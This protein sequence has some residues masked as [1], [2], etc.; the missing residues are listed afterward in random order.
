MK[1]QKGHKFAKGGKRPGAGRPSKAQLAE[2][3]SLRQAIERERE[4]RAGV[5]A[6]RYVEMAQEDPATMRHLVDKVLPDEPTE[7]AQQPPQITFINFADMRPSQ[8][9]PKDISITVSRNAGGD[10]KSKEYAAPLIPYRDAKENA[11][12]GQLEKP[13]PQQVKFLAFAFPSSGNGKRP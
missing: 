5:L 1:F 13:T 6:A 3:E 2:R 9:P 8:L 4:E 11:E 7:W 10:Q 12:Q